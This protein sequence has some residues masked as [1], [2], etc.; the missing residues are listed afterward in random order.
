MQSK[1]LGLAVD[2]IITSIV[3]KGYTNHKSQRMN[4]KDFHVHSYTKY[5]RLLSRISKRHLQIQFNL[6]CSED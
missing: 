4:L 3:I 6:Y 1:T 2:V 5:V